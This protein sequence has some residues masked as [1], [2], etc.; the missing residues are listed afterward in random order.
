MLQELFMIIVS[1]NYLKSKISNAFFYINY[2]YKA[3]NL[4]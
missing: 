3:R 1:V 2:I 4:S